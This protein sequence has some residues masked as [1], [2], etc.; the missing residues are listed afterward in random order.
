MKD[1]EDLFSFGTYCRYRV[2]PNLFTYAW[3]VA[4]LHRPDTKDLPTRRH[5]EVSSD[6]YI[7]GMSLRIAYE[8]I[9][10][11]PEEATRVNYLS[12]F[13]SGGLAICSLDHLDL[14]VYCDVA[15]C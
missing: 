5:F 9:K 12:S 2:N 3:A 15:L 8:T 1:V 6:K 10:V 4:L 14:E 7:D 13:F 11:F